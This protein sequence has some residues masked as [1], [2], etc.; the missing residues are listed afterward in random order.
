[1]PDRWEVERVKGVEAGRWPNILLTGPGAACLR[2]SSGTSMRPHVQGLLMVGQGKVG[3][4]QVLFL[5][6]LAFLST[7]YSLPDGIL[8]PQRRISVFMFLPPPPPILPLRNN[9]S[10]KAMNANFWPT[11][12]DGRETWGETWGR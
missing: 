1:M 2:C 11:V 8:L 3:T 7:P 10:P 6:S 12:G 5:P 4:S 9:L